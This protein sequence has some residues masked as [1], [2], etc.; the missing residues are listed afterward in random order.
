MCGQRWGT[1]PAEAPAPLL[2]LRGSSPTQLNGERGHPH[3]LD[4]NRILRL[5]GMFFLHKR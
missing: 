5:T 4:R 2:T 1:V 3:L